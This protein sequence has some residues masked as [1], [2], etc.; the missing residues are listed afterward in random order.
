MYYRL[1]DE[2]A[3]RSWPEL[4]ISLVRHGARGVSPLPEKQAATMLLCDGEH[5]IETDATAMLLVLRGLIE[6]CEKGERPSAWSV[7]RK[8][9]NAY[10]PLM[11]L[12]ITGKC[13]LNCLHCFNAADNAALMTE[14]SFEDVCGLLDQARD[15]GVLGF[16]ITGGEPM[17]HRRFLDI[18]REIY[19]RNMSVFAINTN[20][21]FMTQEVLDELKAI[22]CNSEMR[23]SFDGIGFHDWMRQRKGAEQSALSAMELCL[24]NGFRVQS[25]TQVNRRNVHV[26][27]PTA[28]LLDDIGVQGMRIIRTTEAPRWEA[29]A[30]GACLDLEEYYGSM[31]D[32]SVEY[33][34]SGLSMDVE[35]W[36]FIGLLPKEHSY[37]LKPVKF[38]EGQYR[39]GGHCC[40]C[41]HCMTAVTSEGEV[42]PCNQMSGYF[43]KHGISMGNVRR[44]PLRD[45][46]RDGDYVKA[47]NMTAGDLRS[48]DG[49]CASCPYFRFCGGGCRALGQLYAGDEDHLSFAHE[50]VTKCRFFEGGWYQKVTHALSEWTNLS[51]VAKL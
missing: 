37:Y 45:L 3:L 22:G 36:Q 5:D 41:A 46:L 43:L 15:C 12:M 44:T 28:K 51:E 35:S 17:A 18:V 19:K 49:K 23:I 1:T 9:D 8:F 30:S 40:R 11:N 2:V 10:F 26:M 50:D 47:A 7:L 27:M 39:D 16:Q 13:N 4:G 33:L 24:Q 6:P 31:L 42:M 32:F 34:H 38:A 20:G 29:N 21:W 25:N 14:W 48:A